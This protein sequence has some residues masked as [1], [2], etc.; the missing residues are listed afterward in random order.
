MGN[1]LEKIEHVGRTLIGKA[2]ATKGQEGRVARGVTEFRGAQVES[3]TERGQKKGI[4]GWEPDNIEELV[5][6]QN[7]LTENRSHDRN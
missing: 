1:L 4:Y 2:N 6:Q 3:Y 7:I 5:A